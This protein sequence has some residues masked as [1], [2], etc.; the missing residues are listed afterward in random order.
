[1][2]SAP[3]LQHIFA[4]SFFR[5]VS[6]G[7]V[8]AI[9]PYLVVASLQGHRPCIVA[10]Y[11]SLHAASA[12]RQKAKAAECGRWC[13]GHRRP[14]TNERRRQTVL[15]SF[16]CGVVGGVRC[17]VLTQQR[18]RTN[19]RRCDCEESEGAMR[20][21]EAVGDDR[22]TKMLTT[23]AEMMRRRTSHAALR[24]NEVDVVTG[25]AS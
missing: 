5:S 14:Q 9:L 4:H 15:V 2:R 20:I 21:E 11:A 10:T 19:E 13:C 18:R 24:S 8:F 22:S 7:Y 23:A 3:P 25:F 16:I 6:S 17:A 1:M 12:Y